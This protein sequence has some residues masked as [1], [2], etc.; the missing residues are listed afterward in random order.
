MTELPKLRKK[1]KE[2][3]HWRKCPD[4]GTWM[5]GE[6]IVDVDKPRKVSTRFACPKCFVM[7]DTPWIRITD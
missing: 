6:D 2:S 3:D 1:V 7:W 5:E 4:C